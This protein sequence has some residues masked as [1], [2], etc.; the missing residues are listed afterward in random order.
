MSEYNEDERETLAM[1]AEIF[2][3]LADIMRNGTYRDDGFV[4]VMKAAM[5]ADKLAHHL[6][7]LG[8]LGLDSC[9][10]GKRVRFE[11]CGEIRGL[12][13]V[14]FAKENAEVG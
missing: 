13:D 3:G 14:T 8:G 10:E 2:G 9:D 6:D 11:T 5:I 7:N 4:Y 12:Y 1:A